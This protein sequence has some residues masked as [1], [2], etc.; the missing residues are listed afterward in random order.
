[1]GRGRAAATNKASNSGCLQ[2]NCF[3]V[4]KRYKQLTWLY[5]TI[6]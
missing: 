6:G 5:S 4:I 2:L 1:M 3:G